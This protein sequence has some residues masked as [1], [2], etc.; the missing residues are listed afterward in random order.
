MFYRAWSDVS[1][2]QHQLLSRLFAESRKTR[3][4]PRVKLSP[5]KSAEMTLAHLRE[6]TKPYKLAPAYLIGKTRAYEIVTEGV[7]LLARLSLPLEELD[8]SV[9]SHLVLDGSLIETDRSRAWK[10]LYSGKHKR[11]GV[12]IQALMSPAGEILWASSWLVGAT[13]DLKAAR[14]HG[15]CDVLA[16]LEVLTLADKGYQGMG[17]ETTGQVVT[18]YKGK[19]LTPSYEAA[20]KEHAGVRAPGER[21]FAKLKAWKVLRKFTRSLLRIDHYVQ[22]VVVLE[23]NW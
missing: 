13:H 15:L 16:E 1:D 14:R 17:R 22:A 5:Y 18:P 20:V 10:S 12:N 6:G 7:T 11:E 21:G 2:T 9:Y 23:Q 19:E 8:L 4:G 3:S